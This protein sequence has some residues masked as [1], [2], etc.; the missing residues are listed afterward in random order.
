MFSKHAWNEALIIWL[1]TLNVA[2]RH[3]ITFQLKYIYNMR[4]SGVRWRQWWYTRLVLFCLRFVFLLD[5]NVS[6]I[7]RCYWHLANVNINLLVYLCFDLYW[8]TIVFVALNG[9]QWKV[10][11]EN[12]YF[13]WKKISFFIKTTHWQKRRA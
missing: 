10:K 8:Q 13:Y 1:R 5:K 12:T 4:S 3:N 7:H 2:K 9:K 6:K 11:K